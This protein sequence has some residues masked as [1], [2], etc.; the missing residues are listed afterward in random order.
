MSAGPHPPFAVVIPAYNHGG[1]VADVI[2]RTLAWQAPVVVVDDG[3]T[4]DTPEKLRSLPKI[5]IL[6]HRRNRGKGA[7]LLTGFRHLEGRV[8][9]AVT[10]DADGQHDPADI[11]TLMSAVPASGKAIVVGRRRGMETAPWTSRSGRAFSNFWV[12]VS[13]GVYLRDTQTGMR[14]YPL[15][16]VM[17]MKIRARRYQFEV[18]VLAKAAWAGIPLIEVPVSVRYGPSGARISHF[19]PIPDFFRN[20]GTFARLIT[21]RLLT[22]PLWRTPGRHKD[23]RSRK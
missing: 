14:V 16:E 12:W 21:R 20:T 8:D 15:P 6:R 1:T 3:S 18:E 7:A 4:D 19:R 17:A 22:P 5:E 10:L 2:R 13:G 23:Q 9:W 11:G